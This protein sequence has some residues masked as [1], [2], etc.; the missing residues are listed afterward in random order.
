MSVT[1]GGYLEGELHD[2]GGYATRLWRAVTDRY[3]VAKGGLFQ[4]RNED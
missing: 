4:V 1:E 3:A 2:G